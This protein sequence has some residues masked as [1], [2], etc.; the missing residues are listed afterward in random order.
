MDVNEKKHSCQM[1]NTGHSGV[2][3]YVHIHQNIRIIH[4]E[5]I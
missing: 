5:P 4:Y 1:D 3:T 2:I